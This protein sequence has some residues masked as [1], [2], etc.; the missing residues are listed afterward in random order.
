MYCI[1]GYVS[2]CLCFCKRC[3]P[4]ECALGTHPVMNGRLRLVLQTRPRCGLIILLL[5]SVLLHTRC[6]EGTSYPPA[7]TI[8]VTE[9]SCD[10]RKSMSQLQHAPSIRLESHPTARDAAIARTT[11]RAGSIIASIPVLST[12]LLPSEKGR[13]CDECHRKETESLKLKRCSGCVS[14]WYCGTT[15][16]I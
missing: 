11:I 4:N 8:T 12:S 3:F 1:Y 10:D 14:F 6:I 2:T 9:G 7:I 5:A 13:R 16:M 15:C